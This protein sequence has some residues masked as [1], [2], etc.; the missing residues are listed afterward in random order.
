MTSRKGIPTMDVIPEH[1]PYRDDGCDVSPSCLR[2]PL[3]RCKY[4]DPG[5]L[6][7][8]RRDH[9]DSQVLQIRRD[10]GA[11]V[12]EVARRFHISQRTVHRIMARGHNG[13]SISSSPFLQ[14][15]GAADI[16]TTSSEVNRA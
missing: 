3:P 14:E 2:C 8:V 10:E 5:W 9:R 15:I 11:T 13:Q 16:E 1:F 12:L 7:R 6:T 4:D